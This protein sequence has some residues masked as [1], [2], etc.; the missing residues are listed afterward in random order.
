MRDAAAVMASCT[1]EL[2]LL[3]TMTCVLATNEDLSHSLTVRNAFGPGGLSREKEFII[4]IERGLISPI[5]K[6]TSDTFQ[7][8]LTDSEGHEINYVKN[9]LSLTM[10]AGKDIAS[11][12]IVVVSDRVGDHT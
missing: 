10:S 2:N 8:I 1:S 3:P 4:K 9:S 5:S 6:E 11:M 12:D 7:V